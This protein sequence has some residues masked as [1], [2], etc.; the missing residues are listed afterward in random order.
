MGRMIR[1][2]RP[3]TMRRGMTLF[4][5]TVAMVVVS[6]IAI[7]AIP[8]LSGT[9]ANVAY[10]AEQLRNDIRHMQFLALTWGVPLELATGSAP[11]SSYSVQCPKAVAGTA[12][13]STGTVTNPATGQAYS[14]TLA[15]GIQLTSVPG[16]AMD[17]DALGRPSTVCS[18]TCALT[19]AENA[20]TVSDGT[21]SWTLTVTRLT[22]I[23]NLA[24]P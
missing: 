18:G 17:M 20:Y 15:S 22:G 8:Y 13:T 1:C 14:I 4:E 10:Q 21:T 11:S 5:F 16:T 2:P 23:L 9:R 19:N 3:R 12:C 7:S 24:T 6:V